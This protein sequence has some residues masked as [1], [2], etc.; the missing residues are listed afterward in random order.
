VEG[1][2]EP[3]DFSVTEDGTVTRGGDWVYLG[4]QIIQL[5][6]V[7]SIADEAYSLNL[8]WDQLIARGTLRT[9]PYTG[10][11]CDIGKPENIAL[12]AKILDSPHV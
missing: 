1:R 9:A 7:E 6:A 12:A 8:V 5:G 2:A 11:W 3:G 10:K 4:V